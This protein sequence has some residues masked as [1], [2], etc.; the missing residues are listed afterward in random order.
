MIEKLKDGWRGRPGNKIFL[1][2]Y[3][4]VEIDGS[5]DQGLPDGQR[6]RFHIN[7]HDYIDVWLDGDRLSVRG[8]HGILVHPFATNSISISIDE[9]AP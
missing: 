5:A 7:E 2:M 8:Q 1:S 9:S 6:I 4:G 3:Y